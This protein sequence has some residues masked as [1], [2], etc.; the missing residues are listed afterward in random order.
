MCA[1][2]DCPSGWLTCNVF[3]GKRDAWLRGG[4]ASYEIGQQQDSRK[5]QDSRGPAKLALAIFIRLLKQVSR[6]LTYDPRS[7]I[8]PSKYLSRR[9]ASGEA[10]LVG[11]NLGECSYSYEYYQ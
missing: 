11:T 10:R 9:V 1:A 8:I 7:T 3:L 5:S 6:Y 4:T 2:R